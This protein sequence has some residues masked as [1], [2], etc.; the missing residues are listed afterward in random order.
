MIQWLAQFSIRTRLLALVGLTMVVLGLFALEVVYDRYRQGLAFERGAQV[1]EEAALTGDLIHQLQSERGLTGG[2]LASKGAA[3]SAEKLK[4]QRSQSDARLQAF[5]SNLPGD[6]QAQSKLL[7]ELADGL[8]KTRSQVDALTLEGPAAI[9]WYTG[10]IDKWVARIGTLPRQA[11]D[12]G[13]SRQ[14]SSYYYLVSAKEFYGRERAQINAALNSGKPLGDQ[15]LRTLGNTLAR[16]ATF[17]SLLRATADP[18]YAALFDQAL[19]SKASVQALEMRQAVIENA[20]KGEYPVAAA[21]WWSQISAKM[22]AVKQVD[23]QLAQFLKTEARSQAQA[24]QQELWLAVGASLMALLVSVS[25][26]WAVAQSVRLPLSRLQATMQEIGQ[27]FELSRQVSVTGRDE[28]AQTATSF[29]QM[30]RTLSGAIR[31]VDSA[32]Q[33][34]AVGDFS[35][36]IQAPLHGDMARLKESVNLTLSSVAEVMQGLNEVT[37]ALQ[38]GNFKARMSV[39]AQGAFEQAATQLVQAVAALDNM[40]GDIGRVMSAVA[41]GD[42]R[43]RIQ[44]SASGDLLRLKNDINGSLEA[45]AETLRQVHQNTRQ[46]ATASGQTNIAISQIADGVQNQTVAL[47]QVATAVRQTTTAV[48]DVSRNTEFASAQAGEAATRT[49]SG[50]QKMEKMVDIVNRIAINSQKI[51]KITEVIEGI[52]NKTN[53]LSL[54]AA[55]EAARAGEHGKGF[56]VVAEEVGKLAQSSAQSSQEIAS[57]VGE[58]VQETRNA[59]DAVAE[60]RADM[61]SLETSSQQT[62]NMLERIAAAMDEQATAVEE[63]NANLNSLDQIATA[64]AAASEEITATVMSLSQLADATRQEVERFSV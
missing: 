29:N 36:P 4:A 48:A 13:F 2:F 26:A 31:E 60:V 8:A 64:N 57:L 16:Q 19:Q 15:G 33:G 50:L 49:R 3:Q 10:Q 7:D 20:A 42:L 55:I 27:N 39:R 30:M 17:E 59:V 58:A 41:G 12:A 23:D 37:Q 56:S 32:M 22:D 6:A 40:T 47:S 11:P 18:Q 9:G 1:M 44:A 43:Q 38:A 63:I 51:N 24:R 5:R 54:N 45:L 21:D 14:I 34:L 25:L 35:R 46:V 61:T 62:R 52:A 53:L 28:I